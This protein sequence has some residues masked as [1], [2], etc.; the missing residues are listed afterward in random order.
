MATE[1]IS[2]RRLLAL[3]VGCACALAWS[4][5]VLGTAPAQAESSGSAKTIKAVDYDS[6]AANAPF[7]DL[8]VTVSQ[9]KD[10]IA[11]GVTVSWTGGKQSAQPGGTVGG[12][13][14]VQ[15]AQC[16]GDEPGSNGTRPDRRTCQYG[17]TGSWG[18]TRDGN[19]MPENVDPRDA[20][21]SADLGGYNYTAIPF[22]AYNAEGIVD[23]EKAAEDKVLTNVTTDSAGNVRL[24]AELI[25]FDKNR[26][27]T[28]L[29][30]NEVKWAPSGADGSGSVPFELQTAMQ[31]PGLGCG[32]SITGAGGATVGQSCWLVI[33]PRGT[34]D[35]GSSLIN[36]PGVWWDA[37]KHHV[38]VKL[39]FK[40]LGAR[41]PIGAA[42]RSLAGSE[43]I[44][45]AIG[46]WQPVV[47]QGTDGAPFVLSQIPESD[48]LVTASD[49]RPSALALTS[50]PL[51]KSLIDAKT[52]PLVYAPMALGG[53][54]IS[55]A[56]DAQ[57]HPINATPAQRARTGLP[58][59][60]MKLTPRLLAKL[61][62]SSYLDSLPGGASKSHLGY[63]SIKDPGKNPRTLVYDPDFQAINDPEW[64]AQIII[65]PSVADAL[66]PLGRSDLATRVWEYILAD[67]EAKAWLAGKPDKWGMTVNPC[68]STNAKVSAKC[69]IP[70]TPL[71]LPRDD[72][73]K[74]DPSEKADTTESDP[75]NGSGPINLV[76][77]RPYTSGFS[78]GAYRVLRGDGMVL[79]GWDATA[80]PPKFSKEQRQLV[81]SR[82]VMALS[83][84]S[85]THVYQTATALLRNPAG[86]YVAPTDSSLLAAAAAMTPTS[87]QANVV[88]FQQG[89]AKAKAAKAAYPL[90]IP[91]YA[92][93]NPKQTDAKLRA[94]Y[95]EFIRYAVGDGQKPGTNDGE[96]PPGYAPIPAS[97]QKQALTAAAT[98]KNGSAPSASTSPTPSP[99]ATTGS[100]GSGGSS[101]SQTPAASGSSG[102]S[103]PSATGT[104]AGPRSGANTPDD[105]ALGILGVA[106]PATGIVG[107]AALLGIPAMA[108]FRRRP[109]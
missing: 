47:C 79:G 9:T 66:S 20:K 4:S 98:I 41:C 12:E 86:K 90:A 34:G 8:A 11:Q 30:T 60:G 104:S 32:T 70:T 40:P 71:Q 106:V 83:T 74:A 31:S 62:T 102:S 33:I 2:T 61:L 22:V 26:Y 82:K 3:A 46:S 39:D 49:T 17:G 78:D 25:Y 45:E 87:E 38:A 14:F 94:A 35:S 28:A 84:T 24:K 56:I 76:T 69:P 44:A 68:Y 67:A 93:L 52:D 91:V 97:W 99:S 80:R 101:G 89:S 23:E 72:F 27:F 75:S 59:T 19:T 1:L 100:S 81:G 92:A 57:P 65:G 10:V 109:E 58:L 85:A 13:K 48:A 96:L 51:D 37:W 64:S 21:Y 105:P 77:Y 43:L 107:L 54:T 6:D 15:I 55:F 63:Q 7:P 53:V 103:D 108:R 16:W 5:A 73:P 18:A 29:T 88:S 95:S 50:K 36:N 42:E